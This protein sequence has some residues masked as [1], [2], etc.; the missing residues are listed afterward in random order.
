VARKRVLVQWIG[1]SD[2]RAMAVDQPEAKQKEIMSVVGGRIP[3][4]E[5]VGPARTLLD[6]ETFDEVIL[7]SNYEPDW[8]CR[9]KKWI[10]TKVDLKKV[11]L[12]KPTDYQTIL[13][14][15]DDQLASLKK[16]ADW[17]N[18]EL[19]LHLSPGTPAMAAVWLPLSRNIL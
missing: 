7:L 19:C 6:R 1:H 18:T 8:N 3:E 5:N 15:A 13:K 10:G 11:D 14:I 4:K 12:K 2:L 9:F 16:R 17:S